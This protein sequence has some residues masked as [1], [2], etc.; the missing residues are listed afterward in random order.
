LALVVSWG[1]AWAWKLLAL[2]LLSR[3]AVA[4]AVGWGVLRDR[5][6]F[7]G[8]WLIPLRDL[9]APL[10]WIASFASW[11][12]TWGGDRFYLRKGKLMR[13]KDENERLPF[14]IDGLMS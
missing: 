14:T 8:F 2:A 11:K 12:V 7:R 1:A 10:V 4:Y 5:Q 13:I 3:L 6:V 9:V